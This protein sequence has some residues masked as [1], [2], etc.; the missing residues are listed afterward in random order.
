[1][2]LTEISGSNYPLLIDFHPVYFEVFD[3][4]YILIVNKSDF[5]YLSPPDFLILMPSEIANAQNKILSF[6]STDCSNNQCHWS[7]SMRHYL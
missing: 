5:S 2:D 4:Q 6:T 3:Y 7:G 1:M